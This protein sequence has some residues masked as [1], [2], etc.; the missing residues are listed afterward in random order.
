M[1]NNIN[2]YNPDFAIDCSTIDRFH[3]VYGMM[4]D[5]GITNSYVYGMCYKPS[6]IAYDFLKVGMS[7]P[8]LGE[9]RE[10]QVGE[11]VVRQISWVP[12]WEGE[13]VRSSHGAD[14]WM[15]IQNFLIP[16]GNVPATF[17]KND[18]TVAVWNI[19][20]RMQVADISEHDELRATAWAEGE[21]AAQYKKKYSKLPLLNVQDPSK[22]KY[23][24]NGYTPK[25]VWETIFG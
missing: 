17:N 16:A 3:T 8:T 5:A 22:S 24:I 11:R 14:F 21:L 19:S 13:H 2:L 20:S 9:K 6:P 18:L 25:S 7:C 15:G 1:F 10:H 23:Y 12:G 4:R